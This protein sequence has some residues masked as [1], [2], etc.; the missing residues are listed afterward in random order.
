MIKIATETRKEYIHL[1]LGVNEGIKRFKKKWGGIPFLP[2]ELC[3][4]RRK[5]PSPLSWIQALQNRL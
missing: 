3:E 1:G 2:Y 4:I 5:S